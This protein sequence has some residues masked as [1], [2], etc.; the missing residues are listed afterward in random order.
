M[1]KVLVAVAVFLF[2]YNSC[3]GQD[4]PGSDSSA[5]EIRFLKV[6]D[7]DQ[8][9]AKAKRESKYIFVDIYATWCGPC[10]RMDKEVY[11]DSQVI[12]E[13]RDKF[14]TVKIQADSSGQDDLETR[15][16][17]KTAQQ[18]IRK[19]NVTGYPTLLFL[20]PDGRLLDQ[21]EGYKKVGD[22]VAL[23]HQADDP[24]TV[25][26][27]NHLDE[28]K[29]G[30]KN[31]SSMNRLALFVKK[32][33]RNDALADSIAVDY[34][35]HFLNKL[36]TGDLGS[37]TYIDFFDQFS[38]KIS[39]T[40]SFFVLCYQHPERIDSI[41]GQKGWSMYQ[42]EKAITRERLLIPFVR[43]GRPLV[44]SPG[45][46]AV[47]RDIAEK[48]PKVDS[49]LLVLQF[50]MYYYRSVDL[51]WKL[52]S[53]RIDEKI[54]KY[55][56]DVKSFWGVF[57]DL[58]MPAWDAFQYC[59]NR[60]ILKKALRWSERSIE[61]ESLSPD[62]RIQCLDTRANLLYKL[63]RHVEAIAQE[64]SAIEYTQEIARKQG[65]GKAAFIDEFLAT[66]EKMEKNLP[67]W[68]IN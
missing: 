24:A 40:D 4:D 46:L 18:V 61:L 31:F 51:N 33:V 52:W 8:V 35:V 15:S 32:I 28:Y 39:S 68:P 65:Q 49:K 55:P 30:M 16:G 10:K 12:R 20:G 62:I 48:Y 21:E 54:A 60:G 38:D 7:W 11:A 42:V 57:D 59:T 27:Y 36:S 45:W 50:E 29:A 43:N 34:K 3:F 6:S 64:R 9:L 22:F 2:L 17:Y 37:R 1:V 23:L 13:M 67:T 53:R 47:K 58:N 56:P 19:F 66:R 41:I 26:L 14:I 44:K 25:D 63:G 5:K